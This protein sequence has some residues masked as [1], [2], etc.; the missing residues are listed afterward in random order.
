[1]ERISADAVVLGLY[2]SLVSSVSLAT[3]DFTVP[4]FDDHGRLAG[5]LADPGVIEGG[6]PPTGNPSCAMG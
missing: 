5:A 1:M 2:L 3:P 6:D 4:Q